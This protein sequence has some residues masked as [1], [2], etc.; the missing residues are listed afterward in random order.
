MLSRP[1]KIPYAI[2]FG[3]DHYMIFTLCPVP[4][5]NLCGLIC[6]N[7]LAT[8]DQRIGFMPLVVFCLLNGRAGGIK[9]PPSPS[10]KIPQLRANHP[11]GRTRSAAQDDNIKNYQASTN[12]L[13]GGSTGGSS[14]LSTSNVSISGCSAC[15]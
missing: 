2:L 4:N 9:I 10:L 12:V 5:T 14:V 6:S 3:G 13:T 1:H 11:L 15:F 7:I 8:L